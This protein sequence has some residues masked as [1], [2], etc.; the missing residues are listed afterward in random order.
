MRM[1]MCVLLCLCLSPTTTLQQVFVC[2]SSF[3]LAALQ[4]KTEKK[5]P[6]VKTKIK[7]TVIIEEV[8]WPSG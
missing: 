8:Q 2:L 5:V 1:C 6:K 4:R 7:Y 3:H